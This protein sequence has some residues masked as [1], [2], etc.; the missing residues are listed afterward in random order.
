MLRKTLGES[1]RAWHVYFF[2]D[3]IYVPNK[4]PYKAQIVIPHP[5]MEMPLFF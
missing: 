4:W 1:Q 5:Q 2:M 3:F